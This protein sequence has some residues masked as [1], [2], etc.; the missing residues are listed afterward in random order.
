[1]E[2]MAWNDSLSVGIDLIDEQHITWIS[3]FNAV[4]DAIDAREDQERIISTLDF[5]GDYTEKHFATEEKYMTAAKYPGYDEHKAKHEALKTTVADLIRDFREDGVSRQ[6][7]D[8][9]NTLLCN[10]LVKHIQ[11]VDT[12]FATFAKENDLTINES[13]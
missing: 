7:A 8:A 6:L 3:R 2:R 1:M 5:L 4:L 9:V 12:A 13:A 11:E 10:W